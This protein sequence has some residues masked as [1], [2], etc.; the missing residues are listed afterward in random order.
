[1]KIISL[2]DEKLNAYFENSI[3]P[4]IVQVFKEISSDDLFK[5]FNDSVS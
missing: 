1:M 2:N 4:C 3:K 5:E